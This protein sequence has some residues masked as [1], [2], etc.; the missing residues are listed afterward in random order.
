MKTDPMT[1][2]VDDT[3]LRW[4]DIVDVAR[5][6][7]QLALSA[8]R[9][10]GIEEAREAVETMAD[11][12][13]A[14]YGINTGLGALCHVVLNPTQLEQLSWHTLMSHACGVG[15]PLSDEQVRA[16]MCCAVVNYSQGC[17]GISPWVVK[18]LV[19]FLN[20]EVTPIVP[21]QGSVG[22]LSHMAHIG[23]ALIGEGEVSYQGKV[24]PC[25]EAFQQIQYCPGRLGAK[26]G[27]SLVNGTPAMTGLACLALADS[28][29]LAQWADV[30]GAM[31]FEALFGQLDAFDPAI[32]ARKNDPEAIEV[33]K[34]LRSLLVDSALLASKQGHHLQDALSLRA[35]PQVHGTCWRQWHHAVEQI[36]NEL[37][38]ATDNPL[39]IKEEDTYRVVSQANPHGEAV[40]QACDFLAIAIS[41]WSAISERR[42]YRLVTPQ[43]NELPAFLSPESGVKSGMMIAQYSAASLAADNKRLAQPCVVD[44]YLTSGLQEDHL[45]FGDSAALK[46]TAALD[47]AFYILAIE[48]LLAAQAFD[49]IESEGF[50]F[51]TT[52]AWQQ[53]REQVAFYDETRS[54]HVDIKRTYQIMR[55]PGSIKTILE[56]ASQSTG[57]SWRGHRDVLESRT[58]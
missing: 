49:L 12:G 24:Q 33:G 34:T 2:I 39:V 43:A 41:E 57:V 30:V 42:S 36:E 4:Q 22:Y 53:L 15:Q 1:M 10:Q 9:W 21:S 45:S 7:N 47:N 50:G 58:Q 6:H 35:I 25:A 16:I 3:P 32:L 28:G 20:H 52:R 13:K 8:E 40:A 19:Y 55:E 5:N 27:L 51:G 29:L 37:N 14:Y 23:L 31:S 11:S 44:N 38:A 54:L 26:D 18:A 46:L 48:Y 17:S 56:G